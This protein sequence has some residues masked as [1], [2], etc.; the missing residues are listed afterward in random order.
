MP[1]W[2]YQFFYN[3]VLLFERISW[4]L[5]AC[6]CEQ[7]LTWW[8]GGRCL[9]EWTLDSFRLVICALMT[10]F[11][12]GNMFFFSSTIPVT[13]L[14]TLTLLQDHDVLLSFLFFQKKSCLETVKTKTKKEIGIPEISDDSHLISSWAVPPSSKTANLPLVWNMHAVWINW[15]L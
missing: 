9:R 13:L 5:P 11:L 3:F 15:H 14:G 7:S 12:L 6:Q 8:R 4:T 2:V 1:S 10:L